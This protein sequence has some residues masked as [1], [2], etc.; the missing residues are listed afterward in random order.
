MEKKD[1]KTFLGSLVWYFRKGIGIG[2]IGA[3]AATF[4][5]HLGMSEHE[6]LVGT[7]LAIGL[8]LIY[9]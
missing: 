1:E 6:D 9:F 4:A 2:I 8:A 3:I 7:G 5:H